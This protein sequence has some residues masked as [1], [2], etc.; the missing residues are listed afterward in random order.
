V[1]RALPRTLLIS[2]L[3]VGGRFHRSVITRP[4]PRARLLEAL[5]GVERLVLL[6]DTVELLEG[7]PRLALA[8]AGALLGEIGRVLG[9]EA[10]VVIV[11]GNHDRPLIRPWLRATGRALSVASEVPREATAALA[12]L[13]AR[14]APA[15]VRV[16]YPGVWL[17]D[18]LWAT[19]GHYL[20]AH[21]IPVSTY[22]LA[23][24]LLRRPPSDRAVPSDYERVRRP[25]LGRGARLLPEI[26]SAPVSS[27]AELARAVTMPALRDAVLRPRLA[28]VTS[29]LLSLQ[30]RRASL[31]ALGRVVHRLGIE[32]EWV[33][34][35]HVHRLGPLDGD[36]Q[37]LWRGPQGTP[38]ML[39]SGSWVWEPRLVSRAS[40]PH[41]YWPGGAV[42]LEPGREPRAV[43]LL[44]E[45]A[46]SAV[47][48][49]R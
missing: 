7:R 30:M 32:A 49:A 22:G 18:E 40:P 48:V 41:P 14:L 47:A 46:S 4:Q 1:P 25:S 39:N 21:L 8:Q 31:P 27:L 12:A 15:R 17:S 16:C 6:G 19:H 20:D 2:D 28:P 10:E 36:D 34:Y 3:H 35:G 5:A 45:L 42:L 37:E 43:G 26:L 44:D 24:G 38:R 9:P 11:P 33:I 29:R 13:C 23:R